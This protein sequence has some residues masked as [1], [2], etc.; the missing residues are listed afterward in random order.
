MPESSL[1]I[2]YLDLQK[3]IAFFLGWNPDPTARTEREQTALDSFTKSGLRQFYFPPPLDGRAT[4]YEW[5][6]L[7]PVT[8]V[9]LALG[10]QSVALPDDFGCLDSDVS[11]VSSDITCPIQVFGEGYVRAAYLGMPD[12]MGRP[13]M[14]AIAPLKGTNVN[15]SQR[16][17]LL[18]YPIANIEYT[19]KLAYSILPEYLSGSKPYAYGGAAHAETILASCLAIAEQRGDDSMTV[20]TV[21]FKERLAASIGFDRRLK[22]QQYGYNGDRSGRRPWTSRFDGMIVTYNG[23]TG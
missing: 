21:K 4:T 19:F 11:L 10:E 16:F 8:T 3:D 17:A 22:P 18:A 1:N 9:T 15:Q 13:E 20:N 14:V 12:R 2:A 5:S 6:F 7:R 23:Q